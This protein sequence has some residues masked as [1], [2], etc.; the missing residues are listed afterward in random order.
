M[1][2]PARKAYKNRTIRV[3]ADLLRKVQVKMANDDR[4]LSSVVNELLARW[5]VEGPG[6][7]LTDGQRFV[8]EM[9]ELRKIAKFRVPA[10]LDKW[11]LMER[12]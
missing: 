8:K 5:A 12:K 11:K 3:P 2:A 7:G 10:K 6:D 1:P 4:K 9:D